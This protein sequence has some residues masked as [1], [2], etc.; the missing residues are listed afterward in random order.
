MANKSL[1]LDKVELAKIMRKFKEIGLLG[2]DFNKE[3]ELTAEKIRDGARAD[4]NSSAK[5]Y[6]DNR[7]EKT[8]GLVNSIQKKTLKRKKGSSAYSVSAGG[9]GKEVMAFVEFG[10][11]SKTIELGGITSVFGSEGSSY[12]LRFKGSDNEKNFTHTFAKPYFFKN[13]YK[14]KKDLTKRVNLVINSVLKKK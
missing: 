5:G 13:V 6:L 1:Q 14:E 3:V 4:F 7:G 2:E 9:S 12:A 10:T 8:A 11:R